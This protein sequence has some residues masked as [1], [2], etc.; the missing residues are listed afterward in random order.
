[1]LFIADTTAKKT[2]TPATPTINMIS[3]QIDSQAARATT[4]NTIQSTSKPV[5]AC[6]IFVI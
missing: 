3:N 5:N 4:G 2:T 6:L 1:M